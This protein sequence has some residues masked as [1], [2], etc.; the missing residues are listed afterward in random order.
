MT[1]LL[2][3]LGGM[4]SIVEGIQRLRNPQDVSSP[5]LGVGIVVFAIIAE[6]VSL[7]MALKQISKVRGNKTLWRWFR[8]TR[9]SELIVVLSED[10]T[11][12]IGLGLALVALLLTI[13]T[14]NTI[15]DAIGSVS[16]GVLLVV[17]QPGWPSKS[18]V[19]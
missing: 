2:F 4:F 10:L 17:A 6:G 12:V 15:Y 9:H 7:R 3:S 16:V 14:G 19:C 1:L 5:W 8:D 11:A 13:A 18:R